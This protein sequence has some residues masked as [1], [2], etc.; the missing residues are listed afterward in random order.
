MPSA[1]A[2]LRPLPE[3]HTANRTPRQLQKYPHCAILLL[4]SCGGRVEDAPPHTFDL[5]PD[6]WVN[7]RGCGSKAGVNLIMPGLTRGTEV[8]AATRVES[9]ES[10][11]FW[12]SMREARKEQPTYEY[13]VVLSTLS[14][15]RTTAFH[16]DR[17]GVERLWIVDS[18]SAGDQRVSIANGNSLQWLEEGKNQFT[19]TRKG[20]QWVCEVEMWTFESPLVKNIQ[21]RVPST[22]NTYPGRLS[23][24]PGSQIGVEKDTAELRSNTRTL[25]RVRS[26]KSEFAS[27]LGNRFSQ[28]VTAVQV[29]GNTYMKGNDD[30]PIVGKS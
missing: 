3:V 24:C 19:C 12:L 16:H 26:M 23:V 17:E 8:S 4:G 25:Q 5:C 13:T 18:K 11:G 27:D 20:S 9:S 14:V 7:G 1:V 30:S 21:A 29:N 2:P 15:V 6:T 28:P 22:E 10:A